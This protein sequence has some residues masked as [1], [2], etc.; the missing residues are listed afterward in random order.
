[1]IRE[2]EELAL[3]RHNYPT[4]AMDVKISLTLCGVYEAILPPQERTVPLLGP[5]KYN[6][7]YIIRNHLHID[8]KSEYVMEEEPNVLWSALQTR[9]EQQKPMILPEANHDSTMLRLQDFKS[10]GEY[11][12]V[13]HKI[14]V[15]LRFCEKEPSK[16]DKIEKT[17]QTMLHL[18]M[19]L[20]H[21]YRAKN[22]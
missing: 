12:H 2:F 7:L 10:I 1:M 18:D 19:I 4:W 16:A 14:C 8:L 9:Y 13:V 20:Q 22:L 3:D 17:L 11:N 5:F 21:Q 6:T 15:K